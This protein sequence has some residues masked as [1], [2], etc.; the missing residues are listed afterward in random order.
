MQI[1]LTR[2]RYVFSALVILC[3]IVST[4]LSAE[5]FLVSTPQAYKKALQKV[6]PGDAIVMA[7]GVW[8]DFEIVFKAK[9][10]KSALISLRGETAGKVILSGLSNL[11]L[12]GEYLKVSGLVFRYGCTF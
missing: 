5:D 6:K 12:A 3:S 11:R 10:T 7:N 2:S 9:G 4:Q 1:S 8:S